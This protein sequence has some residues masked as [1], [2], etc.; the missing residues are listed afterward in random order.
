VVSL[1]GPLADTPS[2]NPE[3]KLNERYRDAIIIV[4][5]SVSQFIRT[6][7]EGEILLNLS[8]FL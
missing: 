1:N 5:V 4:T 3:V 7:E 2:L 8:Y 6:F